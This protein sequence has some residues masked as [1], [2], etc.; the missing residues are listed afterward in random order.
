MKKLA[1][2]LCA[3]CV[4]GMMAVCGYA[5]ESSSS[6]HINVDL[7]PSEKKPVVISVPHPTASPAPEAASTETP[8]APETQPAAETPAP[9]C[10]PE[11]TPVP[12]P[13]PTEPPMD[14]Q[15]LLPIDFS[16]GKKP[17]KSGYSGD[18]KTYW[19][20]E[21]PTISVS[22]EQG[23]A[24][25]A[26]FG[27]TYWVAT[28]RIQDASQLRTAS[29]DGFD[30]EGEIEATTLAKR[31]N[32]VVAIDGDTYPFTGMGLILRQGKVYLDILDGEM[33]V[34]L[35]DEDG[36]FH[37]L[38]APSDGDIAYRVY[39]AAANGG[40][41]N[42]TYQ[43]D[44][45]E[46]YNVYEI[47]GKRIINAFYFGPILVE[48]GEIAASLPN[49]D[50]DYMRSGEKKQR[51]CI[52]QVGPLE[53]KCICCAPPANHNDGMTLREFARV[54]AEQGVQTAYNLDGGYSTYLIFDNKQINN[55][56]N[57]NRKI[58]DIIYFASAYE[59][60]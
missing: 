51:M 40:N 15:P 59:G 31:M 54:V 12:S 57:G 3:L 52:A 41:G 58:Q 28:I 14:R 55:V 22:I 21:D 46:V 2:W 1:A 47:N 50:Y 26:V 13:I 36:D 37:V 39:S 38:K 48:N 23:H 30:L 10:T 17:V 24:K 27:C 43:K 20:Y 4:L 35:V 32:A 45:Q 29:R 44:G 18:G 25:G 53:Y 5:E 34:L 49:L 60:E 56:A 9:T 16:K 8:A 11:P 7:N 42:A 19:H 33:D 6:G